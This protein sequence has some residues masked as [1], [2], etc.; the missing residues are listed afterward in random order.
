MMDIELQ[1]RRRTA[2]PSSRMINSIFNGPP[3]QSATKIVHAASE[4]AVDTN[5][6][7]QRVNY[8]PSRS[9]VK[10]SAN[11]SYCHEPS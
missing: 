9:C 11:G 4:W 2:S 10:Y 8:E 7:L 6:M 5:T 1:V 3:D